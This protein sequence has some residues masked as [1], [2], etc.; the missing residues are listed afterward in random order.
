MLYIVQFGL[1]LFKR[2]KRDKKHLYNVLAMYQW[3]SYSVTA[4][5]HH[6]VTGS[7]APVMGHSLP[8]NRPI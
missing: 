4:I 6:M 5:I 2:G 3:I 1:V 7:S 8:Q